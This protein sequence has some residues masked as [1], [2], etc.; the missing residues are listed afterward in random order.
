MSTSRRYLKKNQRKSSKR[1]Q[2][3]AELVSG[4]NEN[5][6]LIDIQQLV[7]NRTVQRLLSRQP[8]DAGS[9]L[10]LSKA[11]SLPEVQRQATGPVAVEH[12]V[13]LVP[14]PTP[15]SCWAAALTM[16]VDYRDKVNYPVSDIASL[17]GMNLT[18]G[19]G[20]SQIR[21]AVSAWGL[22]ELA[23]VSADPTWWADMLAE[24]GPLWIVEVGAPFH[25]VVLTGLHGDGTPEFTE[26][27]VFN[28]W[29]PNSGAVEHKTFEDFDR[30]FGLG[31]GAGA[32][33]V[34]A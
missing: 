6:H 22:A 17:A 34:H 27:H 25:A 28:P 31:A 10:S 9:D 29:P 21:K 33:I 16:V 8:F 18:T 12:E 2:E 30:E 14:Q 23:P 4:K 26:A 3:K 7:G 19:Y 20:W 24:N 15:V 11:G 5:H 32:A 13:F 1:V